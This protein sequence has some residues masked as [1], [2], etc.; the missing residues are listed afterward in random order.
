MKTQE[1]QSKTN[2]ILRKNGLD[3]NISKRALFD[4]KGI[5]ANYYGLYNDKLNKCI[6]TVK[7][8]YTVSQNEE[9]VKMVL[10]GMQKFGNELSVTKAGVINEGRKIFLQLVIE[11]QSKV[12]D[13]ILKRYITVIDSNDGST[14][15]SVGIGDECMRCENQFWKFYKNGE[16]FR[17]T[18]TI[19]EKIKK[20]PIL[21]ENAL[22]N[23]IK[24]IEI[25]KSFMSTKISK[26]LAHNMVKHLIG[27]DR[28]ITSPI[29][30][31]K[32]STR[33]INKMD[34][35]YDAIDIEFSEVGDTLWGL[36][37]GI[38]RYTTHNLS[39][40]KRENGKVES[41]LIGGAYKMNQKA[42]EFCLDHQDKT[43][44]V[45]AD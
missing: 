28:E 8:G 24:Q 15:L 45:S 34:K 39:S 1:L 41:M 4:D 40:P 23:S 30:L 31:S 36:M 16:K 17:H 7:E 2:E 25:Y 13:D 42:F 19:E 9:I 37:G 12:G 3:F 21:I 29:E 5:A 14:S 20:L 27:F 43:E 32:K 6:H 33:S 26:D 38:T 10:T 18:I 35:I 22:A 44:L 11:G